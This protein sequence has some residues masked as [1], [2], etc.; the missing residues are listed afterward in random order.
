MSSDS[1]VRISGL[2]KI[3]K[4]CLIVLSKYRGKYLTVKHEYIVV[5]GKPSCIIIKGMSLPHKALLEKPSCIITNGM[6]LP[7]KALLEKPSCIIIKGMPLPHK[8]LLGKPSCIII[9]GCHFLIK[10]F[11]V[12]T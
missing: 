4:C 10:H 7:H 5:L 11:G 12:L 2:F 1:L 3:T 9:K 6:L 8:A